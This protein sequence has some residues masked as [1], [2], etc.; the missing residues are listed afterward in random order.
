MA[1]RLEVKRD[2][3]I[4][5]DFRKPHRAGLRHA[6]WTAWPV[7]RK[8]DWTF[9]DVTYQL[10]QR[11]SRTARRRAAGGPEPESCDDAG[12]PLAIEVLTGD[13]DDAAMLEVDR[14]RQYPSVPEGVNWPAERLC[15][16]QVLEAVH[17]EPIGRTERRKQRVSQV[18]NARDLNPLPPG[19]APIT[20]LST[21]SRTANPYALTCR[22]IAGRRRPLAAPR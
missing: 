21:D 20:Q 4:T 18:R 10:Q 13:D 11:A 2:N 5:R 22:R 6:C 7:E 16:M 14:A 9:L 19:T 15:R 12:D 8:R 1:I 3:R 17:L